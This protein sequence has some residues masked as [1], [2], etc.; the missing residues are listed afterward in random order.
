MAATQ[1]LPSGSHYA[2]REVVMPVSRRQRV[3]LNVRC[4]ENLACGAVPCAVQ[5]TAPTLVSRRAAPRNARPRSTSP[6]RSI[7]SPPRDCRPLV[8]APHA[9]AGGTTHGR[10]AGVALGR[11]TRET[12]RRVASS[13]GAARLRAAGQTGSI[14]IVYGRA[15]NWPGRE[16]K[17][18]SGG[19]DGASC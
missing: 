8:R 9:D 17:A 10:A 4:R 14:S 2:P 13:S 19:A 3:T 1:A 15:H 7:A 18:F 5:R 12:A 6:M 16:R 11:P